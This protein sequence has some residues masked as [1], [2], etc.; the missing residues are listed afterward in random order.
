[1]IP[2]PSFVDSSPS[3]ASADLGITTGRML[4]ALILRPARRLVVVV[5]PTI[6]P[7]IVFVLILRI[8]SALKIIV[9]RV[10][11]LIFIV[12]TT[13]LVYVTW[14]ISAVAHH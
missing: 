12:A 2:A 1:M 11:G 3:D 6:F 7:D 14:S 5:V 9:R 13:V 8:H 10:P 4:I